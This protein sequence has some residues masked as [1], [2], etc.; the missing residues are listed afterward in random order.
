MRATSVKKHF[1]SSRR[2]RRPRRRP[3]SGSSGGRG[4]GEE[5]WCKTLLGKRVGSAGAG[6]R[7]ARASED[8]DK[9][10]VKGDESRVNESD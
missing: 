2:R 8:E 6:S 7:R 1:V 9:G 5:G 10:D 3:A 4:A